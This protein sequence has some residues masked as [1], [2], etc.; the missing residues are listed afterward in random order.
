VNLEDREEELGP[1]ASGDSEQTAAAEPKKVA[2][3]EEPKKAVEAPRP[4]PPDY[5]ALPQTYLLRHIDL[6]V[7]ARLSSATHKGLEPYMYEPITGEVVGR[8]S[9]TVSAT[10]P[11]ALAVAVQAGGF[12]RNDEVRE[13]DTSLF[14]MHF[15]A[16]PEARYHMHPRVF[17]YARVIAG[18]EL[19]KVSLGSDT[20]ATNSVAK[21]SNWAFFGDANLGVALRFAGSS[22]GRKRLPRAWAFLE[23]G[24]RFATTHKAELELGDDGP[25]RA[26]AIVLPKFSTNGG[27]VSLGAML[28][29]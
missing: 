20:D 15:G 14:I 17:A 2:K 5:S 7:G 8:L 11:W 16:G 26:E 4:P 25:N 10:D 23:G 28:T 18:A 22:D 29:F 27:M 21:D 9:A 24:G 3:K 12:S 6:A 19:A 1:E 13:T